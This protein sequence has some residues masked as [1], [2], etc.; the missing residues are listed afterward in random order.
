MQSDVDL[1][2][3][4]PPQTDNFL[5]TAAEVMKRESMCAKGGKPQRYSK[6]KREYIDPAATVDKQTI[7][8]CDFDVG[9][10]EMSAQRMNTKFS[11]CVVIRSL[12][13]EIIS[14][15]KF[16]FDAFVGGC[17]LWQQTEKALL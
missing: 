16:N 14:H 17:F 7:L 1:L 9:D 10:F 3:F 6:E 11:F 4:A 2:L 5:K 12:E 8:F 15:K 13:E